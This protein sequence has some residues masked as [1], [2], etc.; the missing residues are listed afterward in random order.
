MLRGFNQNFSY[1]ISANQGFSVVFFPSFNHFCSSR[2]IWALST[3]IAPYTT[4]N[5]PGSD[6]LL[7]C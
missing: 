1:Q 7:H 6:G 5:S 4:C 3:K 2:W